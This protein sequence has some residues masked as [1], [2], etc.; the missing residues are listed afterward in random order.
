MEEVIIFSIFVGLVA[1]WMLDRAQKKHK[2]SGRKSGEITWEKP[3]L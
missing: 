3:K 1:I 2:K